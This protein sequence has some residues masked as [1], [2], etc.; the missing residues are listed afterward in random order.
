MAR[1]LCGRRQG[2]NGQQRPST[3]KMWPMRRRGTTR[4]V[5]GAV[6]PVVTVASMAVGTSSSAAGARAAVPAVR[7]VL[8][9]LALDSA[10]NVLV[11]DTGHCRVVMI[12]AR[13]GRSYGVTLSAGHA[14]TIA[15][16][17]C[18]S[19]AIG[20]PTGLAIDLTGD[21]YVAEANE[22]RIKVIEPS[23]VVAT[24]AGTGRAGDSGDGG[25]ATSGQ[26]D[27]PTGVAV[28]RSGD[29]FIADTANCK[30]RVVPAANGEVLGQSVERDHLYTVAGTG[31]CG[32]AGQG[33]SLAAAQLYDPVAVAVDFAG[34]LLVADQGDQSVLL[35]TEHNGTY[36]GTAVNA[37][38]IAVVVGGT[39]SYGPYVA[40]GLSATSAAAELN[41]PRDIV[42][43]P[44]GA[45]VLSDGFMHVI[46]IVPA[47][48]ATQ[49]GRAMTAGDLYTVAGA[50]PVQTAAGAGDGTR[51]VLTHMGT[52]TGV[53]MTKGGAVVFCDALSGAVVKVG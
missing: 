49:F 33:G 32:S 7:T 53:A 8:G 20:H 34:D 50:L 29:V 44:T 1:T 52:P 4:S 21:V 26:L 6:I 16:G 17:H 38:D 48:S 15:G 18:G 51:W 27:E 36:F 11:A 37:G 5:L 23:G 45:L 13:S 22:Q 43:G 14:V 19:G 39:G 35:A 24:V 2:V 31:V 9:P 42:L 10:G 40:D 41:D 47:Q 3:D 46:R 28:D 12:P 30:V 25:V